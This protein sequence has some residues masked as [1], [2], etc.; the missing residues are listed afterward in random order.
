[1]SD[2][3][4]TVTG[5][6]PCP[7]VILTAAAGRQRDAMTATATFVAEV[8]P[9]LSVSLAADHLTNELI[10]KSGEFVVNLATPELVE[11]LRKL[12]STHGRDLDKLA[13]FGVGT[14]PSETVGAP[15]IDGAYACLECRVVA[16]HSAATYRVH[17]AEVSAFFV[18]EERSP[19]LWHRGRYFS[20]GR[21]VN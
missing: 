12:G 14:E 20:L 2:L 6:I 10:E 17:T 13:E 15:R 3:E 8:P 7:A 4:R 1:M 11:T 19:L 16:S 5:L 9:L 21:R 18:N